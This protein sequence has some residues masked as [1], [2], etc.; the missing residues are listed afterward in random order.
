MLGMDKSCLFDFDTF[1][2]VLPSRACN[3]MSL[4]RTEGF[5]RYI[6]L[7]KVHVA[8]FTQ[9]QNARYYPCMIGG[10]PGHSSIGSMKWGTRVTI[11]SYSEKRTS[12]CRLVPTGIGVTTSQSGSSH[13]YWAGTTGITNIFNSCVGNCLQQ[14]YKLLRLASFKN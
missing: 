7:S 2:I 12:K 10:S 14:L 5:L 3:V 11:V 1:D 9:D 13:Q 6:G 4:A 8:A